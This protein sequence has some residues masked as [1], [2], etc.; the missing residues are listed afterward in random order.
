MTRRERLEAR[1]ERRREWAEKRSAKSGAA[2][3]R[4]SKI[5]DNIPF[6]QPILVGHHSERHARA[7]ASRIDNAMRSGVESSDMAKHHASKAD[8]LDRMLRG[9]IFSD[10]ADAIEKLE[11]KIAAIDA[12]CEL[13]KRANTAFRKAKGAAGW[14]SCLG[15]IRPEEFE[16]T[17]ARTLRLAPWHKLPF[18]AYALTNERANAR[19][20]RK[21]I[22]EIKARET[23]TAQAEEA[24]GVV[25][26]VYDGEYCS[27]TFAEKPS[28]CI[29]NALRTAGLGWGGGSWSGKY[30]RLPITS[31]SAYGAD[32]AIWEQIRAQFPKQS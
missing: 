23:R 5:A 32:V 3:N 27:I 10:D 29:L 15:L 25:V 2:F 20:C 9:S 18:P 12:Q 8:G 4:A 30:D 16:A 19:R 11:Q 28:R 13:M 1:A 14:A 7:D 26:R 31:P 6:G 17:A 22:E 21:R 24:G